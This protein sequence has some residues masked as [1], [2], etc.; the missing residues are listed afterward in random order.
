[1]GRWDEDEVERLQAAVAEYQAARAA[2]ETLDASGGGGGAA[3]AEAEGEG[4]SQGGGSQGAAEARRRSIDRRI[5]LDDIDW[6]VISL[7]R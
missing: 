3:E 1:M 5:V 2:A 7:V 4:G 6:N